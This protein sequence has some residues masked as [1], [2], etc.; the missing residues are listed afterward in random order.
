[1]SKEGLCLYSSAHVNNWFLKVLA[2]LWLQYRR[3]RYLT[4]LYMFA[5]GWAKEW[6][7]LFLYGRFI[8]MHLY[9][10]FEERSCRFRVIIMHCLWAMFFHNTFALSSDIV[11]TWPKCYSCFPLIG[12]NFY[13]HTLNT[14][15]K[16][17]T[18]DLLDV[19]KQ[20]PILCVAYVHNWHWHKYNSHGWYIKVF[21]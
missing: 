5:E 6:C 8:Y 20:L 11:V 15:C 18:N 17:T 16:G 21:N 12:Y 4:P 9:T 2:S 3:L 13:S 1:M 7:S 14:N 19:I 10:W